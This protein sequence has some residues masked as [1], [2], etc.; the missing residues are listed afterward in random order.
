MTIFEQM[1]NIYSEVGRSFKAKSNDDKTGQNLAMIRALDLFDATTETLGSKR[2]A[3]R[4]REV[5]RAREQYLTLL[6]DETTDTDDIE[7][8][9]NYFLAFAV[10]A[11]LRR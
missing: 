3:A 4:V 7:R 8:L 10:A 11:R 2:A 5:R 9:Q 1:G 6:L